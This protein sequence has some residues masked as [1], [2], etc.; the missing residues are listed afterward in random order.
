MFVQHKVYLYVVDPEH[1]NV[2]DTV[3]DESSQI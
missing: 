2:E 1:P 3:R